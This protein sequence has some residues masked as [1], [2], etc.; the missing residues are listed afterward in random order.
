MDREEVKAMSRVVL[1]LALAALLPAAAAGE[2][3]V[4]VDGTQLEVAKY[5]VKG[6]LILITTI[7]GKLQSM[8]ASLV[9]MLATTSINRRAPARSGA[10]APP[11]PPPVPPRGSPSPSAPSAMEREAPPVPLPGT[12][13]PADAGPPGVPSA[14]MESPPEVG[15]TPPSPGAAPL[16]QSEP[17]KVSLAMPSSAWQVREWEPSFDVALTVEKP[18]T[19]ARATLALVRRS[20][21]N[22]KDFKRVFQEIQASAASS[23]GYRPILSERVEFGNYTAYELQFE[24]QS[25]GRTTYNRLV[26]FYSRDLVYVLS[27]ACP[28]ER[29]ADNDADFDGLV[30]GVN[31][32]KPSQDLVPKGS[33]EG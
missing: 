5:E 2:V 30:M 12:G 33:P 21:R 32:N 13:P 19:E 22:Y 26:S 6:S 25:A 4:F 1:T 9:N 29:L 15:S 20:V 8:P 23:P 11:P 24:K 27:L 28:V 10:P 14:M 7:E 18:Q 16:W 17:L 3:V 31:I